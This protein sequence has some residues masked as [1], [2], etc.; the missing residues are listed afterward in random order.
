MCEIMSLLTLKNILFYKVTVCR[1]NVWCYVSDIVHIDVVNF[2]LLEHKLYVLTFYFITWL[3]MFP[4]FI[5][6]L[7]HHVLRIMRYVKDTLITG[8]FCS[9]FW[10]NMSTVRGI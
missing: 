1:S 7:H 8:L 10:G 5:L 6:F 4:L 9:D 2:H 3:C